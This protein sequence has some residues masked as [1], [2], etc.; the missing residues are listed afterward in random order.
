MLLGAFAGVAV[1]LAA[2]GVYGV[3]AYVVSQRSRELGIRLA[4]GARPRELFTMVIV[5][6]MRP[7][8][9]G[10]AA[11]VAGAVALT[12]SIE[13]LLFDVRAVDPTT[14]AGA[15]ITLGAIAFVACAAPARRATRVDPL[16]ALR[17][18]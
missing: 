8:V 10:A 14:Y 6:G 13:S 1:F 4:L 12:R 16:A 5:Q 17:E 3:L 15:L 2:L 7:V 18:E 9:A 11:G